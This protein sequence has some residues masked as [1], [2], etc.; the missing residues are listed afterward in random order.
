M[1]ES[2]P[3]ISATTMAAIFSAF[4]V[5]SHGWITVRLVKLWNLYSLVH[6][7]WFLIGRG[8]GQSENFTYQHSEHRWYCRLGQNTLVKSA[9]H[10]LVAALFCLR[11]PVSWSHHNITSCACTETWK[12]F[13]NTLTTS[14]EGGE[15]LKVDNTYRPMVQGTC[16]AG[17]ENE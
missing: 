1:F 2:L 13:L 4:Y 8:A 17:M 6:H 14:I 7:C 10:I 9:E 3:D 16:V 12:R 5:S 11:K 15:S